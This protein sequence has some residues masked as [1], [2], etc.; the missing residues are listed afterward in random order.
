M[1]SENGHEKISSELQECRSCKVHK[2]TELSERVKK[3]LT[4]LY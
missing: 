3:E 4:Q 1:K 2:E